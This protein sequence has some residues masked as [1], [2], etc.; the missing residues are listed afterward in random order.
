MLWWK[1]DGLM[2]KGCDACTFGQVDVKSMLI[3]GI[4]QVLQADLL[5]LFCV[6]KVCSSFIP[7]LRLISLTF[8]FEAASARKLLGLALGM[9]GAMLIVF[10]DPGV[11]NA[12]SQKQHSG[13][14]GWGHF[15]LFVNTLSACLSILMRRRLTR[16]SGFSPLQV[17]AW[18]HVVAV[19]ILVFFGLAGNQSVSFRVAACAGCDSVTAPPTSSLAVSKFFR[20]APKPSIAMADGDG[21]KDKK[22][23]GRDDQSWTG[24][25]SIW[26]FQASMVESTQQG[27]DIVSREVP[28][29]LEDA[30][31]G[32]R[33]GPGDSKTR[34][35][36]EM[37]SRRLMTN[38]ERRVQ[39]LRKFLFNESCVLTASSLFW[40]ALSAIFHCVPVQVVDMSRAL[41]GKSWHSFQLEVG[42]SLNHDLPTR[43][44]IMSSLPYI[45]S[46]VIFRMYIDGFPE[47]RNIVLSHAN[48]FINN[49]MLVVHFEMVGFAINLDT[50]RKLRQSLF[51]RRVLESPH[52][53]QADYL[54][55][56][57]RQAE[58]EQQN[59]HTRPLKFGNLDAPCPDDIQLEHVLQARENKRNADSMWLSASASAAM[60]ADPKKE[61]V[62]PEL[63]VD[64]Y[65]PLSPQG[66]A[67]LD[68]H[69]S[70]MAP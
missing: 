33:G 57:R 51:L 14:Q 34:K 44:W 24:V 61:L 30:S 32:L 68:R 41:T 70:E 60:A 53:N 19:P 25:S 21:E 46:Q 26:E 5:N 58:L 38:T 13:P 45:F 1:S 63:S 10:L 12:T 2:Q 48:N 64:R 36:A 6:L 17:V 31:L 20:R 28:Y 8:G 62:P 4:L 40:L 16:E 66:M 37:P 18:T 22:K 39:S 35:Q 56:Q 47:D 3:S 15:A 52:V 50:A 23:E 27:G 65:L 59:S 11:W 42:Q 29:Y 55:G 69:I 43:E 49:I 67:M 7:S 9:A 54:A